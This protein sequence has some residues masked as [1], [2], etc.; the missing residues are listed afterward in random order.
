MRLKGGLVVA[1]VA[2]T[3]F[4]ACGEDAS[5]NT[6]LETGGPEDGPPQLVHVHG[7]GLNPADDR[8]YVATHTGLYRLNQGVPELVGDRRWDVMGF[9]VRGPD[10]F[11][12]GGHPS[13]SEIQRK[14]Y[15]PLL[16]FITTIDGGDSWEILAMR[17]EA[18]LHALAVDAQVI[19]AVD[20][21]SGRLLASVDGTTWEVRSRIPAFTIASEAGGRLLATTR[22]GLL[23]SIDGGIT[24]D[25][26]T[27]P[28]IVLV[29][30]QPEG[31]TW[32]LTLDGAV[33]R[34][35]IQHGWRKVGTTAGR[36]EAFAV[37]ADRLFVATEQGIFESS[38]GASWTIMYATPE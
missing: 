13:L 7:L 14:E 9:T 26:L 8:L 36:P 31:G 37:T 19:Y 34:R 25:V 16:G 38:D 30:S 22:D 10:N 5:D 3:L 27:A 1:I 21:S 6:A 18:D 17:G 32:G 4:A 15:P 12:G 29:A 2:A 28:P 20:G 23:E 24:W 35:D 11:I 33:Y